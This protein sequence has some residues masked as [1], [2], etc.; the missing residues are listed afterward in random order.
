MGLATARCLAERGRTVCL[1]DVRKPELEHAKRSLKDDFPD[2]KVQ[3]DIVDVRHGEQVTDWINNVKKNHGRIDGCLNGAGITGAIGKM[4]KDYSDADWENVIDVN[5][6]GDFNC[7]RAQLGTVEKG[8][9]IVNIASI[10]GLRGMPGIS[11]YTASKFGV[12]GLIR[13]AAHEVA[14]DRI[15][16]NDIYPWVLDM[17]LCIRS[18]C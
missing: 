17:G 3:A 1:A 5:L 9:S 18:M 15:R 2:V 14:G 4:M 16:V 11:G 10:S 7:L 8:G 12:R 6:K 13:C